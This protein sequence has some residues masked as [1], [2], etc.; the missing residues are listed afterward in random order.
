MWAFVEYVARVNPQVAI[1]ES[2]QGAF[3]QGHSLMRALRE[4]LESLTGASWTLTHVL[5]N[6]YSV[7]GAALR[8]RYFWV[9]SRVPFGIESPVL[10][11]YPNLRGV[12][13]DLESL[14]LQWDQQ[15]HREY[16][17]V[18]ASRE[19]RINSYDGDYVDGHQIIDNPYTRRYRDILAGVEW[20]PREHGQ[21][22]VRRHYERHGG[23][24]ESWKHNE[25]KFAAQD[26]FMGFNTPVRW[27]YDAPA[28]VITGSG[29]L[30]VLHPT[31]PRPLT[32]RE[33]ARV[34]GFPDDWLIDPIKTTPGL[35]MTWGKGITVQCGRWIAD[36]A[37]RAIEGEPG[38]LVGESIGDREFLV[39]VTHDWKKICG[40]VRPERRVALS[41]K[42]RP[43]T[44]G[45]LMTEVAEAIAS[46]RGRPRPTATIERDEQVFAALETAQTKDELAVTTGLE[47]KQV[48]LSL[49]RLARDGRVAKA[50]EAGAH[51]WSR[52]DA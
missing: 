24:P 46:T 16:P 29:P 7:G 5:H 14:P 4:R 42:Q 2:V 27:P 32:H 15:P 35:M 33:V 34:M 36:W 30:N 22:V 18:W 37:R 19:V 21:M 47:A 23:L 17:S 8:P 43:M 40:R 44:N 20:N 49:W 51:R 48:Y 26:F 31:L 3:K 12:I 11:V 39:D 41:P 50:R 52:V 13:G 28:R 1:F 38:N 25:A 6:A 45:A 10:D 9:A